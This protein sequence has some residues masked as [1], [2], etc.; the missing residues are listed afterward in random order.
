MVIEDN[1][2]LA[3]QE[4]VMALLDVVRTDIFR[5]VNSLAAQ[6]KLRPSGRNVLDIVELFRTQ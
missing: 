3:D 2:A 6:S 4:Q 1:E 5:G